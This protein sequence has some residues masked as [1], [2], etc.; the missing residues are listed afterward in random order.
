M[1]NQKQWNIDWPKFLISLLI[2]V[3]VGTVAGWLIQGSADFY[4]GLIK[5][6][7]APPAALFPLVWT[8][9]YLLMGIAAYRVHQSEGEGKQSALRLYYI[10]LVVNFLWP[11]SFFLWKNFWLSF[12]ILMVLWILVGVL[13]FR[14]WK[15]DRPAGLMM[16]LYWIWLTFA[17]YL[18]LFVAILY[19]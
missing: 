8:V 16:V 4:N 18:N 15:L 3:A 12:L 17:A 6:P 9:L 10:Q 19:G 1:Q 5:P 11:I 14:F 7:F 13:T 2:P